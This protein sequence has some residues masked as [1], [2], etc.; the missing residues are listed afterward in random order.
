MEK[1][2]LATDLEKAYTLLKTKV[3]IDKEKELINHL[4]LEKLNI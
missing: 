4:E 2:I 3:D 1:A